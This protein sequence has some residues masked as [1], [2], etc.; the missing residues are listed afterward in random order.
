MAHEHEVITFK[1]DKALLKMMG[2]IQNRSEFIRNAILEALKNVCPFCK[3]SGVMGPAKKEHW[4]EFI[5]RHK[6]S[7]CRD[8]EEVKI[9]CG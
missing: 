3:G 5:G 8:C 1:A 6:L 7:E 4:E 2:G 9:E